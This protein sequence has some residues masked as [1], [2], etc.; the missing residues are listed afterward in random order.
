MTFRV[1]PRAEADLAE[2]GDFIALDDREA[3]YRFIQGFY[4][5]FQKL[6]DFPDLGRRRASVA[7]DM[8]S[9][10]VGSYLIFYRVTAARD[11]EIVRVVH[12][13]RSL[14]ALRLPR[15]I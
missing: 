12:G 3:A 10:P 7:R 15:P 1:L 5:R 13:A 2:I 8:R 11:V 14:K 9:F 4:E 6:S